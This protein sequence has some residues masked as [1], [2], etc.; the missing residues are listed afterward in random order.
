MYVVP[1]P[2]LF[3]FPAIKYLS[4]SGG[5]NSALAVKRIIELISQ[6]PIIHKEKIEA[7]TL[8]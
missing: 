3:L 7:F 1:C 8:L 5:P 4:A 6:I 2:P